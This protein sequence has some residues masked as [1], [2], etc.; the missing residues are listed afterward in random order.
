MGN[1][2]VFPQLLLSAEREC[3]DAVWLTVKN[4]IQKKK[5]GCCAKSK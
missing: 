1:M 2:A 5:L 3:G 4:P